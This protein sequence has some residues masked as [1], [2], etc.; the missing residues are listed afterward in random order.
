MMVLAFFDF[1]IS[2]ISEVQMNRIYVE[3]LFML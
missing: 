1:E 3:A 2:A